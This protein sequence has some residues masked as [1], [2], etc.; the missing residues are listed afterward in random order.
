[1]DALRHLG[2]KPADA[3]RA[4]ASAATSGATRLE[5]LLRQALRG[6][7]GSYAARARE[8]ARHYVPKLA[9]RELGAPT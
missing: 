9:S 2:V 7:R 5:D 8:P 4:I 1:M 6:L 3:R